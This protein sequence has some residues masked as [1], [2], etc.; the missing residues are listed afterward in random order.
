M[1]SEDSLMCK[2]VDFF[3]RTHAGS[4]FYNNICLSKSIP[5][6]LLCETTMYSGS[7]LSSSKKN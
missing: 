1:K 4:F 3:L 7:F 6:L 5:N 2:T